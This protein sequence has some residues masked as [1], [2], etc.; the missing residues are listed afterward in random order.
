MVLG[1]EKATGLKSGRS[2]VVKSVTLGGAAARAAEVV[3]PGSDVTDSGQHRGFCVN[4]RILQIDEHVLDD[5]EDDDCLS[6]LQDIP[7]DCTVVVQRP[8]SGKQ[9]PSSGTDS[10]ATALSTLSMR[11]TPPPTTSTPAT[12]PP[13]NAT[14][15]AAESSHKSPTPSTSSPKP[16]PRKVRRQT[17]SAAQLAEKGLPGFVVRRVTIHRSEGEGLG[18]SIV[19]SFGSTR[20]YYQVSASNHFGLILH[21]QLPQSTEKGHI[22][23]REKKNCLTKEQVNV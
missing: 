18:L 13:A 17:S 19:P 2:V 3:S 1:V 21:R 7:E 16:P 10:S 14:L 22:L 4:D 6:V 8:S 9:S 11:T 5:L 20:S 23:A 15:S 12:T